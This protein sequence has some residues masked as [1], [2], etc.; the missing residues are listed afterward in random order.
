MTQNVTLK[1]DRALLRE[2][3]VYATQKKTSL[4]QLMMM[5]LKAFIGRQGGYEKAKKKAMAALK[6]GFQLGGGSYYSS[7][8]DLHQRHAR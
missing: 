6:K 5:A 3:K 8:E 2:A 1:L 4:S 7:R